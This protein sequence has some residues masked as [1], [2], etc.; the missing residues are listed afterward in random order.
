M[1][2]GT[3][4]IAIDQGEH[5]RL[6]IT[7]RQPYIDPGYP[8]FSEKESAALGICRAYD[9][10]NYECIKAYDITAAAWGSADSY[11][12]GDLCTYNGTF[13]KNAAAYSIVVY[14]A[15]DTS[16]AYVAGNKVRWNGYDFICIQ[17][18][19]GQEPPAG[20]YW[21]MLQAQ[22]HLPTDASYWTETDPQYHL[23]TNEEY[24]KELEQAGDP[25]DLSGMTAMMQI[26]R[27]PRSEILMQLDTEAGTCIPE[28]SPVLTAALPVCVARYDLEIYN[29]RDVMKVLKGSFTIQ[30]EVTR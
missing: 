18:H 23:P 6:P 20:E 30:G 26:R 22:Y 12:L 16:T 5:F 1:S 3:Y 15:W 27:H 21:Q 17:D 28:I 7:I 14:D 24:W 25:V 4:N 8:D 10:K 13:Y 19:S 11:A 29:N 2:A 9:S